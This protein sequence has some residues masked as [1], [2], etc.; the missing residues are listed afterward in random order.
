MLVS[1]RLTGLSIW[2]KPFSKWI[3]ENNGQHSMPCECSEWTCSSFQKSWSKVSLVAWCTAG[4]VFKAC[5]HGNMLHS[6][7][8][9]AET[10]HL[11]CC[12]LA[13]SVRLIYHHQLNPI[14]P[15]FHFTYHH[16]L[17]RTSF[18]WHIWKGL[19]EL[20][21][22]CSW[23]LLEDSVNSEIYDSYS[24]LRYGMAFFNTQHWGVVSFSIPAALTIGTT[25]RQITGW[26][27]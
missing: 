12:Q 27:T 2:I 3:T 26:A 11:P 18:L 21:W 8:A 20:Y 14:T 7:E 24:Q 25:N 1:S 5:V 23:I 16:H 22:L 6:A 13:A 9:P 10:L 17:P 19:R 15:Y 4:L